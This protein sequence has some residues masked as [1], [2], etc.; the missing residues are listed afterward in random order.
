M[1]DS[2]EDRHA[3]RCSGAGVSHTGECGERPGSSDPGFSR[4][5]HRNAERH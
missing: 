1:G 3:E 2:H 4:F 5:G